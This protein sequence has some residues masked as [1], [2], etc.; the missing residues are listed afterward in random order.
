MPPHSCLSVPAVMLCDKVLDEQCQLLHDEYGYHE[1][2]LY[3][4]ITAVNGIPW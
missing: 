3:G 2:N 1:N 4:D